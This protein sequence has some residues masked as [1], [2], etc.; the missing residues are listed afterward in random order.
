MKD[1]GGINF[2]ADGAIAGGQ[3][4]V[5]QQ[6]GNWVIGI[7]ADASWANIKGSRDEVIA[8]PFSV[9]NFSASIASKID[10]VST[11]SARLGL[12]QDRWLVYVKGGLGWARETHTQSQVSTITGVPGAQSV[13]IEGKENRYGPMVGF[14]AEYAFLGNWSA[15]FE[16]N[17]F[18]FTGNGSVRQAGTLTSFAGTTTN[19]AT[20]VYIREQLHFAKVGLNYRFGPEGRPDIAP[21]RPVPGYDWTGFYV[22]VEG[23]GAGVSRVG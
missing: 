23:A 1:W 17:Y 20:T 6:I 8:I 19:V 10:A 18:D 12:A 3:I 13:F 4:G 21:S 15:K 16:Y 2:L 7:E 9:S 11:I 14:G 22:G 5:N